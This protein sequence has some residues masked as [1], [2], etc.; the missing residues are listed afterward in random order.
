MSL[1]LALVLCLGMVA[2]GAKDSDEE[3]GYEEDVYDGEIS[4][5][6]LKGTGL[7]WKESVQP[8]RY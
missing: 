6:D 3:Y 1:L 7:R 8:R 5:E 4:I 2:C